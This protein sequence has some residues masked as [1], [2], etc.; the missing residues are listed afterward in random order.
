MW[1]PRQMTAVGQDAQAVRDLLH[2]LGLV[3]SVCISGINSPKGVTVAGSTAGLSRMEDALAHFGLFYKRLELDY[4]FH[5]PTMDGLEQGVKQSLS[6]LETSK[7]VV[8]FYSTVT[9]NVLAGE[10]LDAEYWWH[11]VRQP[12]LFEQAVKNLLAD[13]FNVCIEVGPHPV[14]RTYVNV[15]F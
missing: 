3:Q 6:G 1:S 10:A 5:S 8:P 13:G 4:A 15:C 2:D 12:V 9:G 11:N 7:P 14:L